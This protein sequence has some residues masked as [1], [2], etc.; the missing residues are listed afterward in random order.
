[1]HAPDVSGAGRRL[2]IAVGGGTVSALE[3]GPSHRRL[4]AVF[5]HANGFNALTYRTILTPL[6]DSSRILAIDLRGHGHTTLPTREANH[7]WN[8]FADDLLALLAA[9]GEQ[10]ALLA[11]HSMGATTCLLAASR[12]PQGQARQ[13]ILFDPVIAPPETY[14]AHTPDW[15]TAIA[16]GALRRKNSF[17]SRDDAFAQYKRRGA[18]TTWPDEALR[19]YIEGGIIQ[20]PDG[21]WR[22]ACTP[23]WE[24]TNFAHYAIANPYPALRAPPAPIHILR[25]EQGS[26]CTYAPTPGAATL[27]VVA[28]TTHFLPMERSALATEALA[29][30][31]RELSAG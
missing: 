29:Q 16:Q 19:D 24:A 5:L 10:P 6:A 18:F 9:I 14:A 23:R 26:T 1:M 3:Y 30:G 13:L 20:S 8:V 2:T 11:G 21:T 28:N 27:E 7:S 12:L 15:T 22:L 31:L 4:D 17:A 25:A